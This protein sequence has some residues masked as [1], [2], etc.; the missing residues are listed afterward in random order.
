MLY[1]KGCDQHLHEDDFA[2]DKMRSTGRRYKCRACSARE[3]QRWKATGGY[4]KRLDKGKQTRA[5]IKT[6]NPK[7][8]WAQM[9]LAAS[10]M[11][12][13]KNGMEHALTLDWLLD[14]A[15]DSCPLLGTALNYANTKS[16]VDSPAVD[17]ID[18]TKGYTPDNCW[19]ISMLANRIKSNATVDQIERVAGNLRRYL[20]A[21]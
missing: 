12:A 2:V 16:H 15:G 1:C 19:V 8:R 20:N 3:Y 18:N 10:K 9:A 4:A 11:R 7:L 17:R 6:E 5:Q 21:A 14:A 13:R